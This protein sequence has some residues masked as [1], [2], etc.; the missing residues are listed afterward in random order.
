MDS[1]CTLAAACAGLVAFC[2]FAP[3]LAQD[4]PAGVKAVT[5]PQLAFGESPRAPGVLTAP[6][7]G[8]PSRA[9]YYVFRAKYPPN[10]VNQPHHHPGDE[11]LTILSGTL[12]VGHGGTFDR[13]KAIAYPPGSYLREPAGSVHWLFTL[14]ETVEVEVR[15]MGPRQNI[16]LK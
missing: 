2:W 6:L 16:Y 12:Y 11:E 4:L 8:V 5:P 13:D 3:V 1:R 15:G 9:E 7:F 14:D 10:T